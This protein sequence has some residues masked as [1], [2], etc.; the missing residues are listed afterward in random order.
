MIAVRLDEEIEQDLALLAKKCGKNRSVL[1]RE[2]I[3]RY[4]EDNEDLE[5]ARQAKNQDTSH[6]PLKQLRKELGLG[7]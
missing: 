4:L 2:A 1:V 5:L 3:L 6:K 7:S